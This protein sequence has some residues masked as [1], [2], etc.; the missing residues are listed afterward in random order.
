LVV[1][2][3]LRIDWTYSENIHRRETIRN[4]ADL[5]VGRL[6]AL[7]KHC[8]S[9]K[10][11]GYTPSDFPLANFDQETLDRSIGFMPSL[12]DV[13]P[14]SSLQQGLLFHSLYAP[15]SAVYFTQ[16]SCQIRGRLDLEAF[17]RAWRLVVDRHSILRT[18]F[19]W[20]GLQAPLQI[21]HKKVEAPW[22]QEDWRGIEP[23]EQGERLRQFLRSDRELGFDFSRA[24]L[25][26]LAL[27]RTSDD[28]YFFVWSSHHLLYDAWSR[29]LIIGE[30]FACYESY[31]RHVEPQ[32]ARPRSYRDYI[33]WLKR[34]DLKRADAFWREELRGFTTPTHLG[35]DYGRPSQQGD[36]KEE[37]VTRPGLKKP[38]A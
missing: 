31:I 34:Q 5:F 1:N 10:A 29:E 20:K 33:A 27:L 19:L 35:C 15:N 24:P 3:R 16:M 26:R 25:M 4:L 32:L 38:A 36:R 6:R 30:V 28:S 8:L 18:S 21:V 2:G 22:L 9:P 13:Y 17:E 12:E 14:L 7:I 23:L 37:R 11:F